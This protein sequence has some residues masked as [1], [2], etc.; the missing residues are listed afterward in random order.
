[1]ETTE[2]S[3]ISHGIT[4]TGSEVMEA[5]K[6]EFGS[7]DYTVR[8]HRSAVNDIEVELKGEE[9]KVLTEVTFPYAGSNLLRNLV[10]DDRACIYPRGDSAKYMKIL[11][12]LADKEL[13]VI[14]KDGRGE[15]S[16]TA[17]GRAVI[18]AIARY[19]KTHMVFNA[20]APMARSTP[21]ILVA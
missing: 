16:T 11:G 4:I 17:K 1:M 15:I 5:K 18:D 6:G 10:D 3:Q 12:S 13:I 2:P 20:L 7:T 9:N 14:T 19:S 21:R 8:I